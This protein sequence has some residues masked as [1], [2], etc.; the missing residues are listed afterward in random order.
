[1]KTTFNKKVTFII[2]LRYGRSRSSWGWRCC[3]T[4]RSRTWLWRCWR[5]W[6]RFWWGFWLWSW[7]W[8]W[9][10]HFLWLN[11]KI[12]I[13]K[14]WFNSSWLNL[15]IFIDQRQTYWRFFC[16]SSIKH[17]VE[18][19]TEKKDFSHS[20]THAHEE[21]YRTTS[22][23]SRVNRYNVLIK[24]K[25]VDNYVRGGL[26]F[27]I[28]IIRMLSKSWIILPGIITWTI[29]TRT[30]IWSWW[31][32]STWTRNLKKTMWFLLELHSKFT[33]DDDILE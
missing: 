20:Q 8:S 21:K 24:S 12:E 5:S 19:K 10:R 33:Y 1:M 29:I 13:T 15:F 17:K 7:L 3:Y 9:S 6:W 4:T 23:K 32:W 28:R 16:S 22:D 27:I 18:N 14:E 25:N 26:K 11:T 30:V 31:W 2:M